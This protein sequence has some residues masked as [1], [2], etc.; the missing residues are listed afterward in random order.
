MT[1]NI[2]PRVV[3]VDHLGANGPTK[4]AV[5]A[6]AAGIGETTTRKVLQLLKGEGKVTQQGALWTVVDGASAPTKKTEATRARLSNAA[7]RDETVHAYLVTRGTSSRNVVAIHF[8]IKPSE[9]YLSLFRLRKTGR[10]TKNGD[11]WTA[12]ES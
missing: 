6:K 5:L 10:A 11:G 3:I 2:P 12:V 8:Q 1:T 4:V 9:A 7:D